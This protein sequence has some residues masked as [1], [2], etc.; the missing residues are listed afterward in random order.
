MTAAELKK[1]FLKAKPIDEEKGSEQFSAQKPAKHSKSP[2]ERK[3]TNEFRKKHKGAVGEFD[4]V[5][6]N[7]NVFLNKKGTNMSTGPKSG[8]NS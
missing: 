4:K 5:A 1:L 3:S 8:F 2:D 7:Q 6:G